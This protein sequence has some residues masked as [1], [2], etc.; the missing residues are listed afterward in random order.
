MTLRM[1]ARSSPW[2]GASS[3]DLHHCRDCGLEEMGSVWAPQGMG[4]QPTISVLPFIHLSTHHSASQP[5]LV[6]PFICPPICLSLHLPTHFLLS[7]FFPS[8]PPSSSIH[9]FIRLSVCAPH[10]PLSV[11]GIVPGT[12]EPECRAHL[13]L[14]T[15]MFACAFAHV[16][17]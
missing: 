8:P 5:A 14:K 4:S 11:S 17:S 6:N 9:P 2:V 7:S 10:T 15:C 13:Y 16:D 3:Q 12:G 1:W